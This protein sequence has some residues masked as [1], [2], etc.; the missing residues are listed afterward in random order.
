MP[1]KHNK[2]MMG[3]KPKSAGLKAL[4]EKN[5]ELEYVGKAKMMDIRAKMAHAK[6]DSPM[7]FKA[8]DF[9]MAKAMDYNQGKPMMYGDKPKMDHGAKMYGKPKAITPGEDE[10]AASRKRGKKAAMKAQAKK[11]KAS[12]KHTGTMV[13]VMTSTGPQQV[14]SRSQ[15]AR[16]LPRV[17]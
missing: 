17:N 9:E 2:P 14:D 1:G 5:P 15:A 4:A 10:R 7:N 13:T 12:G 11:D 6:K 8:M 3:H 16:D